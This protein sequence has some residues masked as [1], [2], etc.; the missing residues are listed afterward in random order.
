MDKMI[1]KEKLLSLKLIFSQRLPSNT[2]RKYIE[3]S[4]KNCNLKG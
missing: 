4:K 3:I 1:S 2:I